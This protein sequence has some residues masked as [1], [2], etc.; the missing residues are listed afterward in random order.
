MELSRGSADIVGPDQRIL[1]AE[2]NYLLLNEAPWTDLGRY[3]NL[4]VMI[5]VS[6]AELDRRLLDRWAQYGKTADEAMAKAEVLALRAMAERLEQNES[7]PVAIN[8]SLP[9]AA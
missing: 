7:R 2:G 1:I 9:L 5:H 6:E 8:I 4:T 3:F